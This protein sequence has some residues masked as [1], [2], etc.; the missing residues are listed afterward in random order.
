VVAQILKIK[1][2]SFR[3][4]KYSFFKKSLKAP[5]EKEKEKRELNSPPTE[6]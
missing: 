6:T 1:N 5:K 2:I 4:S 3:K